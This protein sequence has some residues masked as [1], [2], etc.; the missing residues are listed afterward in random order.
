VCWAGCIARENYLELRRRNLLDGHG[1]PETDEERAQREDR[2][3]RL[4]L[5]AKVGSD[6]N[7]ELRGSR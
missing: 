4:L 6:F 1:E 5:P 7:D 3:V 2:Q